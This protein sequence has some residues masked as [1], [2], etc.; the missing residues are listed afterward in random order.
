MSPDV[1]EVLERIR[2]IAT[3]VHTPP[4]ER[5]DAVI[6]IAEALEQHEDQLTWGLE[7]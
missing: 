6:K 3:D 5:L 7:P 4:K 2:A 1:A